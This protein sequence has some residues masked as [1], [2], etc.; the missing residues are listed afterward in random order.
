MLPLILDSTCRSWM[1]DAILVGVFLIHTSAW[2]LCTINAHVDYYHNE[3]VFDSCP[4][5]HPWHIPVGAAMLTMPAMVWISPLFGLCL[6]VVLCLYRCNNRK[7]WQAKWPKEGAKGAVISY[8][9]FNFI[10]MWGAW[11]TITC[12]LLYW[13]FQEDRR[14]LEPGPGTA[15]TAWIPIL[16][17]SISIL[18]PARYFVASILP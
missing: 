9:T 14:W 5:N 1:K 12:C 6:S 7:M 18:C 11:L 10:C 4:K 2:V 13:R 3:V 17:E 8:A 15:I 16:V